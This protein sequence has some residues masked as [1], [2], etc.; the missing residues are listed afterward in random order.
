MLS[1]F[2]IVGSAELSE[3]T[4]CVLLA[5][6]KSNHRAVGKVLNEGQVLRQHVF[7]NAHKFFND[8]A[9]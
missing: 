8:R 9:R 4:D 5:Y 2:R 3:L 7:V 6:F 1:Y